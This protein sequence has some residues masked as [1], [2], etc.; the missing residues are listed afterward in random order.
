EPALHA[1][2]PAFPF[3]GP[4]S[5]DQVLN[6][7]E[8]YLKTPGGLKIGA[9][10]VEP[11]LGRGGMVP[12]PSGFLPRLREL[13]DRNGILLILDEILTGFGRCG[14]WFACAHEAV[15][16]DMIAAGK[17]LGGGLPISVCIG[18]SEIMERWGTSRGGARHT[19]T[20]LGHPLSC[21]AALAVVETIEQENLLA[22]ARKKGTYLIDRLRQMTQG[23]NC[24]GEIRGRGMMIG[25]EFR[26][27]LKNKPDGGLAWSFVIECMRRGIIALTAGPDGNVVSLTPPLMI[28]DGLIEKSCEIMNRALDEAIAKS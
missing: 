7:I 22:A 12:L 25:I 5:R 4:D 10:L 8:E 16:P 1:A 3:P 2:G 27:P 23:R 13:C 28:E 15:V 20:F 26:D 24:V 6:S 19:S 18:K 14:D 21:A 11:I 17:A 9:M